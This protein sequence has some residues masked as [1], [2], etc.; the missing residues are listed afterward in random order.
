MVKQQN[1]VKWIPVIKS[2]M[3]S[4]LGKAQ[5]HFSRDSYSSGQIGFS[6]TGIIEENPIISL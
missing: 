2:D 1:S 5:Y 4:V 3:S 6:A